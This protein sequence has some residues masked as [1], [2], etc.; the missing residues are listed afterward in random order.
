M[1]AYSKQLLQYK[2]RNNVIVR[3][4]RIPTKE[5]VT[6]DDLS[7]FDF[8]EEVPYDRNDHK[9]HPALFEGLERRCGRAFTLDVGAAPGN[10]QVKRFISRYPVAAK[11]CVAVNVS[12]FD[13]KAELLAR[14]E[15]IYANPP[16]PLIA[17]L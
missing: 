8:Q 2:L 9:L 15:F 4:F 6:A 11:G 14:P 7:R 1:R 3:V 10:T 5:N 16:W 12:T 13:F 17:P